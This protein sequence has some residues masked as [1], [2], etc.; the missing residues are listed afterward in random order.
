[1]D[2]GSGVVVG[3]VPDCVL[4]DEKYGVACMGGGAG[5]GVGGGWNGMWGDWSRFAILSPLLVRLV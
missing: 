2:G 3:Y 1:M 5:L 4:D